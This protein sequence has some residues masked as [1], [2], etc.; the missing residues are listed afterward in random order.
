MRRQGVS[1][2]GDDD[3][4]TVLIEIHSRPKQELQARDRLLHAIRTS[5]K[6]GLISSREY[7]DTADPGAFYAVQ[8]WES[9][10]A[11]RAHLDAAAAD[12]MSTAIQVLREH[13]RTVVL[14]SVDGID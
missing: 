5:H 7:E 1:P 2:V 10:E 9:A 14:R 12:G 6:P 13:P 8:E 4:V 11:F 3:R